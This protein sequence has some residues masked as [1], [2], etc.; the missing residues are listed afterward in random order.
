M[1]SLIDAA[2]VSPA[3][4]RSARHA[5]NA[6]IAVRSPAL[7]SGAFG[8]GFS[9]SGDVE[10]EVAIGGLAGPLRGVRSSSGRWRST[11]NGSIPNLIW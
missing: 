2:A 6:S 10:L 9:M 3:A 1:T 5:N 4:I 8:V 7:V 11:S